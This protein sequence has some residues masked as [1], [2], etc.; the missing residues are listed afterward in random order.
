MR[1]SASVTYGRGC[2]AVHA[3]PDMSNERVIVIAGD[4]NLVRLAAVLAEWGQHRR[5]R[6][7]MAPPKFVAELQQEIVDKLQTPSLGHQEQ[8]IVGYLLSG[9]SLCTKQVAQLIGK[10]ARTILRNPQKYG[11]ILHGRDWRYP[12]KVI[13]ELAGKKL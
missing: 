11:G 10:S 1:E 7:G 5:G 3:M 12:K 2:W 9:T 8:P 13:E 4:E 6:F